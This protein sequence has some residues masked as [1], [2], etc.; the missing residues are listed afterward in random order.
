MTSRKGL[1]LWMF[2][3]TAIVFLALAPLHSYAATA[4][5]QHNLVSDIPL[6]ADFTDPN[7]VNPWGI[8]FSA[9]S[10]FWLCDAGTGLSTV[11]TAS[12]TVT[13]GTVSATVVTVPAT[14][15][16][17]TGGRCTGQVDNSGPAFAPAPGVT[18]GFIF[19]TLDGSISARNGSVGVIKVDNSASGAVYTGLALYNSAT[20]NYLYAANF[21]SGKIDVFDSNY[22]PA[23]L[24]GS[25]ADPTVPAGFAPFNIQN[26]GGSLYV[27]YAKQDAAK[28]IDVPGPGNGYVAVFDTNGNLVKHLVSGGP[29]NS[30]WGVQIA[31]S[32]FGDFKGA[33][34]VGNFRDG[35]I[36]AFD[37]STGAFLGTLSDPTGK[38]V[39][40]VGLWGLQFGNGGSGGDPTKLYFAA[41]IGAGGPIQSHG[42]FGVI[43]VAVNVTAAPAVPDNSVVNNASYIAGTN[44]LAP[45]SIAAIFGSNLTDGTTCVAP[46]CSPTFDNNKRLR[47]SMAGTQVLINGSPVPIFYAAPAQLGIQIPTE[48]TGTSAQLQVVTNGQPSAFK[49]IPIGPLSPGIFSF[50]ADG[51]G[52]GAIT[53][54]D[55]MGTT[56]DA[57]NPAVPGETIV[58]Y[59]TGFGQVS[60]TVPTGAAPSASSTTVTAPTVTIDNLPASVQFSGLSGCCVGLNQIN[61]VVPTAVS[62]GTAVNVVVSSGGKSANTVTL[63]TKAAVVPTAPPPPPLTL[64][65][66]TITATAQMV[67]AFSAALVASGGVPPYAYFLSSGALPPELNLDASMGTISGSPTASGTFTFVAGV[68]DST[69]ATAVT[70]AT[71]SIG[72]SPAPAAPNPVPTITSLSPST[73]QAGSPALTLTINGTGF[74]SASTVTYSGAS[75]TV[76]VVSATR[77]TIQL[78]A[79]DLSTAGNYAV[80]V[81]NPLPGGGSSKASNVTVTPPPPPNPYPY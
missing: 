81:T 11:Y 51:K 6:L 25:F 7:L 39:V 78:T 65:F 62:V 55:S 17:L 42:L 66:S 61:V 63:Q 80:V 33:L 60:P 27:T 34:L 14:T 3:L 49:T 4:Y 70:A 24:S 21:N 35:T 77:L 22:A 36:N 28:Q 47:T 13:P 10:P 8:S 26:L 15:T 18:A 31:P 72:V 40:N 30:P 43:S 53:H 38:P 46:S 41:G 76:T 54:N 20:V 2:F 50:T 5:V 69:G 29:L 58:I 12:A 73:V 79:S 74:I 59:G 75:K 44:A 52:A 45:G 57:N 67:V 1:R 16:K 19:A 32:T 9:T 71:N 23:T 56:V 37:A 68:T 64:T 48:L